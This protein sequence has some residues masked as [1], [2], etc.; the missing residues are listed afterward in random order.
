MAAAFSS[1]LYTC[2]PVCEL[3][4]NWSCLGHVTWPF[5]TSGDLTIQVS[6]SDVLSTPP[7]ADVT[8][9]LCDTSDVGDAGCAVIRA[10]GTTDEAGTATLV[11]HGPNPTS[12]GYLYL[13]G[14]G[15]DPEAYYWPYPLSQSPASFS[16]LTF[17]EVEVPDVGGLLGMYGITQDP[18]NGYLVV[19]GLDCLQ[20]A[21]VGLIYTIAPAGS[22]QVLY[23]QAGL[24]AADAGQTTTTG[25]GMA[26]FANV[27]PGP[28]ILTAQVAGGPSLGGFPVF[29]RAGEVTQMLVLP[30]PE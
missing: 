5:G 26:I 7:S 14:G 24:F 27:P 19:K 1:V 23:A 21:G 15:I 16:V 2:A 3:N 30:Q 6:I 9:A 17:K 12:S 8:V 18:S 20:Y 22:S 10:S 4:S 13:S 25:D 29:V 11:Q 28:V